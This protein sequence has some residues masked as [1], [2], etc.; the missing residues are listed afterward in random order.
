MP[1]TLDELRP[2]NPAIVVND[3]SIEFN[4][5]DLNAV[6]VLTKKYGSISLS[7]EHISKNP[8]DIFEMA[9]FLL[10]DKSKFERLINFINYLHASKLN[11]IQIA[12]E[13]TRVFH[14]SVIESMPVV[15][16]S[17]L[18]E[19]YQNAMGME[20]QKP[21][22]GKYYDTVAKRYSYTIDEFMK[23]TLRQLHIIL[24]IS[25][26]GAYEELE[27]QA[28]LLG[29]QLKPRM[30]MIDIDEKTDKEQ[31]EDAQRMLKE[32]QA[33]HKGNK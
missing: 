17:K 8:S 30:K 25:N 29:K 9:Y 4:L 26:D 20:F 24:T 11:T 3:D 21:C 18:V 33:K 31:D 16:N 32:L 27:V 13:L 19:E 5:L 15:K 1:Y 6:N 23:L 12:Q 10:K 28:A 22:Y 14:E 2:L 7:V